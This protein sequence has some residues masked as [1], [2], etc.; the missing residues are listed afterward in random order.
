M[1][2]VSSADGGKPVQPG[3]PAGFSHV[4]G[5]DGLIKGLKEALKDMKQGEKRLLI[6][7]PDL[8]YGVNT[9]LLW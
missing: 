2:F 1:S 4:M 5:K 9:G 3:K 6:I 7:P 8:A